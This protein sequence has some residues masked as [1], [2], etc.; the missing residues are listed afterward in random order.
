[1][2]SPR[3]VR[4]RI[5][6]FTALAVAALGWVACGDGATSTSSPVVRVE[7]TPSSLGLVTDESRAVA[8]QAF[9]AGGALLSRVMHWSVSDPTVISVSQAGVVTALAPGAAQLAASSGGKSAVIP[10]TVAERAVSLLRLGPAT[11]TVQVGA[12]LRLT[13]ELLDA[14]GAVLTGRRVTWRSSNVAAATV[15][16]VGVVTGIG[17][18]SVTITAESGGVTGTALVSVV[19]APVATV[20]ITPATVS[21]QTGASRALAVTLRDAAGRTLTGR[22]VTWSTSAAP[23][24]NVSSTGTVLAIAPGTAT[25]T[26][27]SEGRSATSQV[28]VTAI[29][30]ASVSVSPATQT[31]SVGQTATLVSRV[32]DASGA[33]L[34]GRTVTWATDRA[35][36]ATVSATGVV[37]A[38]ATGTARITA[39]SEGRS[40]SAVITVATV[41]VASI[42]VTPA[43]A[44]MLTGESQ[45]LVAKLL[46]AQGNTL[47]GRPVTWIGG[48]P[49]VA[50][51]DSTG[52]VRAVATGSAVIVASSEGAR[53]SVPVTVSPI[54]VATV[55]VTPATGSVETGKALQLSARIADIRNRVVAGKVASWTSSNPSRATVSTTG[56]VTAVSPGAVI[57]TATSDGVSGSAQLT[58]T[59]I[60]VA[61]ITVVPA[62]ASLFTGRTLVLTLQLRSATGAVLSPVGRTITWTTS[63]PTIATVDAAGIVTTT[64]AGVATVTATTDSVSGSATVT[65]SNIPVAGVTVAPAVVSLTTGSALQLG[66]TPLDATGT[67][68][69]GRTAT[70]ASDAPAVASVDA[71]GRVSALTPGTARVTA[72]IDGQQGGATV[73]VSAI[74]VSSIVLA[75]AA[76]SVAVGQTLAL[77]ATLYGPA[78]NV[79]L[80]PTG[81]TVTWSVGNTTIATVSSTGVLTGVSAGTTTVTVLAQ[82]PGQLTPASR[83]VTVTV[84]P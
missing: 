67:P 18:G 79:P 80:S 43:N 23:I 75:P 1:M 35:S 33:V 25:I 69:V 78:P 27:R 6:A 41:P 73:T 36:V 48:A 21:L 11:S 16:S 72:T 4:S 29:P 40:G 54:T 64:G 62:T 32:A 55:T 50:T 82:S 65:V 46:D 7:L 84:V 57:I 34:N 58:V 59:P 26:A 66:A 13:V 24:A 9:G 10:V 5:L 15:D 51:V 60:K 17:A 19:L 39:T 49:N 74:P 68:I 81:R 53:A 20:V 63:D 71:S 12:T 47:T 52:L 42:Q 76:P 38:V 3:L 30:V 8:A 37:T 77:T 31:L 2:R 14:T 28:T 44:A 61:T 70:W 22:T 56:R 45:R 83:T